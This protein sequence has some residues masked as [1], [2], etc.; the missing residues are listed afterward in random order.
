VELVKRTPSGSTFSLLAYEQ[1]VKE[2]IASSG[3]GDQAENLGAVT[4]WGVELGAKHRVSRDLTVDISLAMT[5]A[6]DE[7][8]GRNVPLVPRTA[9]T[10]TA[11]YARAP[12]RALLRVARMG[13]RSDSRAGS[14][15]PYTL[16]DLRGVVE[17]QWGDFFVGAEN[18]FDVV[19]EDE[20]GFPQPGRGFEVGIMRNLYH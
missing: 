15:P 17:T 1:W 13:S 6:R 10:I 7:D 19:Y 16:L 14:L 3:W 12:F 9:G 5:T 8:T 20:S 2:M 18:L 11:S 4:S